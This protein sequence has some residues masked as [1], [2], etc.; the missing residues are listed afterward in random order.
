M[1]TVGHAMIEHRLRKRAVGNILRIEHDHMAS[2]AIG[3]KNIGQQKT[4]ALFC[5]CATRHK[6]GLTGGTALAIV[7]YH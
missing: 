7:S 2:T 3:V 4:V 6:N 5:A 1:K